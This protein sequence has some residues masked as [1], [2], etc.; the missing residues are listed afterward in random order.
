MKMASDLKS[1]TSI[2][3]EFICIVLLKTTFMA[4]NALLASKWL[5]RS[6]LRP[7]LNSVISITYVLH[8]SLDSKGFLE[9]I[10]TDN[11]QMEPTMLHW[12]AW[13]RS[14]VK[15]SQTPMTMMCDSTT[16]VLRFWTC[17]RP[18]ASSG[19]LSGPKSAFGVRASVEWKNHWSHICLSS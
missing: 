6:H 10:Q 14:Q 2:T 9:M 8:A 7:D 16:Y 4:S 5:Q 12:L 19:G 3:L 13:L 17:A 1:A 18:S 15:T 11:K